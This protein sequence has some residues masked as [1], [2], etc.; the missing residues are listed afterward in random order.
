MRAT[1][2]LCGLAL[3]VKRPYCP[4]PT[5]PRL[6]KTRVQPP[7]QRGLA[8]EPGLVAGTGVNEARRVTYKYQPAHLLWVVQPHKVWD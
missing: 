6:S 5:P 3:A 2:R 8:S 4:S 7:N 1:D